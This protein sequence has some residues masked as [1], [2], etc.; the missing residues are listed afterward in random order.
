L[1]DEYGLVARQVAFL[2]IGADRNTAAYRVVAEDGLS[3]FLKLRGGDF[4]AASVEFPNFLSDQGVGH[5]IPPLTTVAG[6]LWTRLDAFAVILYPF[7]DGHNGYELDLSDRHW[8]E[9]GAVLKSIHAA[10]VPPSLR[11]CIPQET[12]SP[13]WRE[14]VGTFLE[15][16]ERDIVY[17]SVAVKLAAFLNANRHEILELVGRAEQLARALRPQSPELVVCHSDIHAGN[18]LIDANDA[19]YVVDWDT[20][21]LAPKER[22]LMSIGGGLMGAGH[23][24]HEE[25][26]LFYRGYGHTEIDPIALAYYRYERIIQDIAVFCEQI[27]AT[28]QGGEDREQ[29]FRYLTANFLPGSTIQIAYQSD[30]TLSSINH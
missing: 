12:Y 4:D 16:V 1:R 7:V 30:K 21:T 14:V 22:D 9:F 5:I 26:A 28:T 15:Q 27:L 6:R 18:V 3:Y 11:R 8:R 25:E 23:T 20:L 17:D 10:D 24:P 13:Q 19:F 29:S 2:P